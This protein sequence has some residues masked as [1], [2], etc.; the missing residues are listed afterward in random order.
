MCES[1]ARMSSGSLAGTDVNFLI[2][3]Q[4]TNVAVPVE[5]RVTTG[6]FYLWE[7]PGARGR[8]AVGGGVEVSTR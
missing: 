4:T 7:E 5:F 6:L 8:S 2:S 1:T 3:S